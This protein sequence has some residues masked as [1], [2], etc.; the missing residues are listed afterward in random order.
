MC[1]TFRPMFPTK[2]ALEMDDLQYPESWRHDHHAPGE[3]RAAQS[4]DAVPS[5]ANGKIN[6]WE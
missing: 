1:D 6:T 3:I 4:Q 2:A 5:A